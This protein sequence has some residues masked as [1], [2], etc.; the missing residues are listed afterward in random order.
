ML[1]WVGVQFTGA[2]TKVERQPKGGVQPLQSR[3][4]VQLLQ[5]RGV[6]PLQ[7]RGGCSRYRVQQLYKRRRHR[8]HGLAKEGGVTATAQQQPMT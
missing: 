2:T 1:W 3:G 6:Q 7:P 4:G 5:L 8:S